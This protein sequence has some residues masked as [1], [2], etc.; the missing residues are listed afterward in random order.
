[1]Q[2][3]KKPAKYYE[4]AGKSGT[5]TINGLEIQLCDHLQKIDDVYYA[6]AFYQG[7]KP[8]GRDPMGI[9][10]KKIKEMPL[11]F[12]SFELLEEAQPV[13]EDFGQ[14]TDMLVRLISTMS[15]MRKEAGSAQ[16]AA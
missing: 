3:E 16:M 12:I 1:M 8:D 14:T 7:E 6:T 13:Y 4:L 15:E 5:V 11:A 10:Y 2:Y 9:I